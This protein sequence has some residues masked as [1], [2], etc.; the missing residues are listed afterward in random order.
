MTPTK[1]SPKTT[2]VSKK[3]KTNFKIREKA[4]DVKVPVNFNFDDYKPL[5]K[6]NFT[7]EALYFE[8]RRAAALHQAEVFGKKAEESRTLGSTKE[9]RQKK[10]VVKMQEKM[11]ELRK[12]L[13]DQGIDVKKLLEDA[14]AAKTEK[15]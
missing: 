2:T 15:K 1:V 7:T 6:K 13:E 4:Y 5:K 11:S 9:R 8:H 10:Q 3:K 12:Q 14:A